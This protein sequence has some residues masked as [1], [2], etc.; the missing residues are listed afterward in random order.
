MLTTLLFSAILIS[1]TI[2]ECPTVNVQPDFNMTEFVRAKWYIHQQMEISYLPAEDNYCVTAM[3]E[4]KSDT[5]VRVH[6]YA[7]KDKVNGE[8]YDSDK[9]LSL[10]G[11]IC[12]QTTSVPGKLE[13]GPCRLPS[14]T[15]GDYWILAAGP[16]TDNYEYTLVS[17]GQ[18]TNEQ[19][20]GSCRTGDGVNGSGL[21][22]F[23]RSQE[24][25]QTVVDYVRHIAGNKGFDL[26]VLG[27]VEQE[28]CLYKPELKT[29]RL[30]N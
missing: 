28:G 8:V 21:W 25:N 23:T 29:S 22:I 4:K 6:N 2:S 11:G 17:G 13:V 14:F 16:S 9:T 10:L 24:R 1:T 7:N 15:Y 27:D 18:P 19:P 20:D 30:L 12:G 26:T 3:Y 5:R